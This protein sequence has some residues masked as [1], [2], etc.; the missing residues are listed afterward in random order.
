MHLARSG[1]AVRS[2]DEWREL[3]RRAGLRIARRRSVAGPYVYLSMEHET[4]ACEGAVDA[5]DVRTEA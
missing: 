4:T 3:A 5:A 1:G 2:R